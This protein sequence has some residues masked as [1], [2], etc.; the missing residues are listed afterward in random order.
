MYVKLT[1]DV[2]RRVRLA[3]NNVHQMIAVNAKK[4]LAPFLKEIIGAWIITTLDPSKDVARAAT[5]AFE[6]SLMSFE[7]PEL[8]TYL[9][10]AQHDRHALRRI[11][12]RVFW[13]S[14][15]GIFWSTLRR[16]CLKRLPRL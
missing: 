10:M 16:C 1:I 7:K 12:D 6:V 9:N 15:K 5:D 2:D 13:S 11:R 3:T 4:K 8:A 14:A